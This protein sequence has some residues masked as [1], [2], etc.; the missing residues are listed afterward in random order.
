MDVLSLC[1]VAHCNLTRS[2][3]SIHKSCH[4][5]HTLNCYKFREFGH[6]LLESSVITA[7]NVFSTIE[8][9]S[10]S[11]TSHALS[12]RSEFPFVTVPHYPQ[13]AKHLLKLSGS[14]YLGYSPLVTDQQRDAW[15]DYTVNN[16]NWI[17]DALINEGLLDTNAP[18]PS[19]TMAP[20][21]IS[22]GNETTAD[23]TASA[24]TE[25]TN[26]LLESLSPGNSDLLITPYIF[27]GSVNS[28]V[29]E[30]RTPNPY[31]APFWQVTPTTPNQINYNLFDINEFSTLVDSMM[32]THQPVLSNAQWVV[33]PNGKLNEL[34]WPQSFLAAPIFD[35]LRDIDRDDNAEGSSQVFE[36]DDSRNIV[37]IFS[38]VIPWHYYFRN[39]IPEESYVGGIYAVI[40]NTCNQQFTYLV[41]GPN[42]T[43]IGPRDLH[44]R[45]FTS[46]GISSDFNRFALDYDQ[47]NNATAKT[48]SYTMSMY[49]TAEFREEFDEGVPFF[50]TLFVVLIFLATSFV[51]CLYDCLVQHRQLKV[52][53]AAARS[54]ALVSTL[55]PAQVRDRLM[56]DAML[57]RGL[58]ATNNLFKSAIGQNG[59][60]HGEKTGSTLTM[61]KEQLVCDRVSAVVVRLLG[62]LRCLLSAIITLTKC[63]RCF[64]LA[65][66]QTNC[67]LGKFAPP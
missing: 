26:Q 30:D 4:S 19:P 44:D 42:V 17:R 6:E 36:K 55:F 53:Q 29:R 57:R 61:E 1:E 21:Q 63:S 62:S 65:Q 45:K 38:A 48:C 66:I 5:P 40:N 41:E 13:R 10:I 9:M 28:P 12:S 49:P 20:Q 7:Q 27:K 16:Q 35:T 24:A 11:I 43:Y 34:Y 37:A 64:L 60:S 22:D 54:A 56:D 50:Y 15:E 3:P 33:E 39:V 32:I 8:S 58:T 23:T 2:L 46:L 67:R 31:Y 25:A 52:V 18:T 14:Y 59:H 51:F 47:S